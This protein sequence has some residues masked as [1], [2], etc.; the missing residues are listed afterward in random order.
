VLDGVAVEA[1]AAQQD[2]AIDNRGHVLVTKAATPKVNA[3]HVV[4]L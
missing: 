4:V 1:I 2:R 3:G